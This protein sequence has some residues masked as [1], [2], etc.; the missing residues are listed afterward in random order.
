MTIKRMVTMI[1]V[2]LAVVVGA[3]ANAGTA[4][5][6]PEL[7]VCQTDPWRSEV[8]HEFSDGEWGYLYRI[9]WCVEQTQV[10]WAVADVVPVVPDGSDCT[11][12]NTKAESLEPLD[13]TGNW[14]GFHMGW[15]S[16]ANNDAT[17]DDYPWGIIHLR[18]DGTSVIQAQG[19]A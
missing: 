2:F 11:W 1:G 16:C 5:A 19:T 3:S 4:A 6:E 15:F 8:V 12:M 13:G 18:P 14:L 17:T 9:I 7:P 10:T